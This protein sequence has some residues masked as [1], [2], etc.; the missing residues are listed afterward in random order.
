[1]VREQLAPFLPRVGQVQGPR[2]RW[3]GGMNRRVVVLV[4]ELGWKL[5]H[6]C[7]SG[8]RRPIPSRPLEWN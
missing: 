1:M 6:Q 7:L 8:A 4:E 2:E 3:A 5:F